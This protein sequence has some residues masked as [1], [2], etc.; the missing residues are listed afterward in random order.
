MTTTTL[1][2]I[3]EH[4]MHCN[5]VHPSMLDRGRKSVDTIVAKMK[6]GT[7]GADLESGHEKCVRK[8]D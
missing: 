1:A 7:Y 6:C 4:A 8:Y 2:S 5:I 3:D